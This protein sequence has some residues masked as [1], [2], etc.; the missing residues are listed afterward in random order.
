MK[1]KQLAFEALIAKIIDEAFVSKYIHLPSSKFRTFHQK[2][3]REMSPVV[4][5]NKH[6][7]RSIHDKT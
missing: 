6:G 1:F 4:T 3:T 7:D 2:F 5:A